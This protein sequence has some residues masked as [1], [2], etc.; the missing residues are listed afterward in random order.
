[1]ES[2]SCPVGPAY[3]PRNPGCASQLKLLTDSSAV[4]A[5][6]SNRGDTKDLSRLPQKLFSLSHGQ[7]R[8]AILHTAKKAEY[9]KFP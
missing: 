5:H 7:S 3:L 2:M 9:G 6:S 8:I 1:M 4:W